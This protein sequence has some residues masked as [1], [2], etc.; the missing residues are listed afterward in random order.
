LPAQL[1][2]LVV[3]AAI[4]TVG[5]ALSGARAHAQGAT[6]H[7]TV[8]P[9]FNISLV[10]ASG[11]AVTHL[12]PGTYT[13][14]VDDKAAEHDFH[15]SGPGVEESTAVEF[16][17]T[18]TWTVTFTDGNYIFRCDPHSTL[19]HGAFS[20]GNAPPPTTTTKKPPSVPGKLAGTVG[21]GASIS[22]K[23]SSGASAK[24]L[25]AGKY[26]VAVRDLSKAQNFHL[27][28]PGVNKSTGVRFTGRT[29]WS[30][31][32]KKGTYRFQSDPSK[33]RV[34]GSIGVS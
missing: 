26:S 6:L 24:A 9:A 2:N 10:D 21:P 5:F 27:I 22:L 3:L 31:T 11:A 15:L 34:H 8:G 1:R 13:I 25:K 28:G 12:D 14:V 32:L 23:K 30:I 33:K 16:I 4:A 19:M 17:G 20:V 7:G 29:T 18:V